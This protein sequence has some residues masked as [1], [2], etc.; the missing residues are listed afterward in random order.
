MAQSYT[1][2]ADL[3]ERFVKKINGI[4]KVSSQYTTE[5]YQIKFQADKKAKYIQ[6][7]CKEPQCKFKLWFAY[8][9]QPEDPKNIVFKRKIY[10]SHD[11]CHHLKK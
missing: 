4:A 5:D 11:V 9:G 3:E 8:E 2:L 7:C 10:V 1:S 6:V